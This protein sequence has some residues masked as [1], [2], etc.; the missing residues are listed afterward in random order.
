VVLISLFSS[1]GTTPCDVE[2]SDGSTTVT[3]STQYAYVDGAAPTVTNI[4]P[5]RGGTGGGT[6]LTITGTSLR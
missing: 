3:S 4:S 1:L 6:Q 5:T 2:V